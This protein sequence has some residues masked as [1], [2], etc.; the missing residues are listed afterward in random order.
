MVEGEVGIKIHLAEFDEL[1]ELLIRRNSDFRCV[2]TRRQ[3]S[4][5]AKFILAHRNFVHAYG[6]FAR[7]GKDGVSVGGKNWAPDGGGGK[8]GGGA[9]SNGVSNYGK[10]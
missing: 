9:E 6:V 4:G 7:L 5:A 8:K 3:R 1:N 10:R 2:K